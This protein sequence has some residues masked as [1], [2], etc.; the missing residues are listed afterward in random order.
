MIGLASDRQ[1]WKL[2]TPTFWYNHTNQGK[3]AK[4]GTDEV[5][6]IWNKNGNFHVC[7][8]ILICLFHTYVHFLLR[9]DSQIDFFPRNVLWTFQGRGFYPVMFLQPLKNIDFCHFWCLKYTIH[10]NSLLSWHFCYKQP[11]ELLWEST[12]RFCWWHASRIACLRWMRI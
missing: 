6:I 3:G 1:Y 5:N 4:F 9:E 7:G 10:C 12:V 11:W 2:A 8:I